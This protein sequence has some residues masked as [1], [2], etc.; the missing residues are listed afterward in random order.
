MTDIHLLARL[1]TLCALP[2]ETEWAE[3]KHNNEDPEMIGERLSALANSAALLGKDRAYFVWGIED[4]THRVL[5]TTFQ[6]RRKKSA[7]RIL[8][9]GSPVFLLLASSFAS[10]SSWL[11]AIRSS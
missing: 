1:K 10:T 9:P 7:T 8:N 4:G 3:F 11:R 2:Q 5:G 6:P